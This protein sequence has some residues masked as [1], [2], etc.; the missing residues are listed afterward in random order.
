MTNETTVNT[1]T[2]TR[3]AATAETVEVTVPNLRDRVNTALGALH[4]LTR[5]MVFVGTAAVGAG[6]GYAGLTLIAALTR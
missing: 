6:I 1:T 2:A 5:T 4:P 3:T